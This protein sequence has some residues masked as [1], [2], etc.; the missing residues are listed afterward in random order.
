MRLFKPKRTPEEKEKLHD[1]RVEVV[2]SK[3]AT[4]EVIEK[5][6]EANQHLQDLL[7]QN[8]FHIKIYIAAGGRK[9]KGAKR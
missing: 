1:N 5:A 9:P 2:V 6:K 8:H 3:E 4:K 7:S